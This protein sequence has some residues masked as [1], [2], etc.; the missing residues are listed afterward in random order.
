MVI[1]EVRLFACAASCF[2]IS[3][4]DHVRLEP[5]EGEHQRS[6]KTSQHQ[7][8]QILHPTILHILQLPCPSCQCPLLISVTCDT[9]PRPVLGEWEDAGCAALCAEVL[10]GRRE[11]RWGLCWLACCFCTIFDS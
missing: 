6:N 4:T 1:Y 8:Q 3:E 9:A 5:S 2:T 7:L 11:V 10:W